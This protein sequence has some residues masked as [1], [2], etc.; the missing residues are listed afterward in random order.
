MRLFRRSTNK[1]I[2]LLFEDEE[3]ESKNLLAGFFS[4]KSSNK[5]K[6]IRKT[7]EQD[8]HIDDEDELVVPKPITPIGPSKPRL[9]S[10]EQN[11][12]KILL[13]SI[14]NQDIIG[15]K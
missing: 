14:K 5:R 4:I 11:F 3:V 10:M 15:K 7:K 6:N 1:I 2:N 9:F 8:N 13:T 12:G